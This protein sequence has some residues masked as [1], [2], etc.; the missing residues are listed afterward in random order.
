MKK[1]I[2]KPCMQIIKKLCMEK[3]KIFKEFDNVNGH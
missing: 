3:M 1:A 2:V